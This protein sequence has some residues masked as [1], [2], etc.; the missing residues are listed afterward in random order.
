LAGMLEYVRNRL[1][2]RQ[3]LIIEYKGEAVAGH[4]GSEKP[5]TT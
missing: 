4:E 1:L 5:V 2:G 3:S